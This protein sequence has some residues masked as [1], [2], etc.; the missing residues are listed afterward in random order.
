MSKNMMAKNLRQSIRHSL[1]R[2]IAIMAIIALGSAM[3]VGLK[4]TKSDMVTTG[5]EYM[6]EHNMFDLRLL[7]TYGWDI[8]SVDD[9][10]ALDGVASAEG[11]ITLDALAVRSDTQVERVYKLYAI[12]ETVNTVMLQGGRMPEAPGECLADGEYADDSALG[13]TYTISDTNDDD[14][15]DSLACR[16][17]TVVGYVSTPLYMDMSRGS[18]TIGNGTVSG[19]LY[20]PAESFDVDYYTEIDVTID[21]DYEIY[22]EEYSTAMDDAA[23][24]LEPALRQIA[25]GRYEDIRREA[26]QEYQDGLEEFS[27]ALAEYEDGKREAELSLLDGRQGLLDAQQE[28]TDGWEALEDADMQLIYAQREVDAG[29]KTLEQSREDFE[30]QKAEA[31]AELNAKQTELQENYDTVTAS[32]TQIEAALAD[33]GISADQLDGIISQLAQGIAELDSQ[34]KALEPAAQLPEYAALYQSLLEQ[35]AAYT[36][37]LAKLQETRENYALLNGYLA[38]LNNGY[39]LLEESRAAVEAELAAAEAQIADAQAQLDK[40]QQEIYTGWWEI[41]EGKN[42][43]LEAEA[44][45]A[46]GWAEYRDGREE[47]EREL[48]DAQ[49]ELTKAQVE[50]AD[51][52][53]QIDSLEQ[54]ELYILDRNTN[55]GY[56]SLDSNS[57][58]VA[59]VAKVFPAFFLLVASLVC[60]TTMTRMVEEERTQIGTL[61]ALGYSNGAI[62]GKYLA[63]A[64]SAAVLGCGLGVAVG[65]V[66]FPLVLWQ[67]YEIIFNITPHLTLLVDMGL[68]IP[69]VVSYTAVIMLVTW[70][71]CRMAL[72]DVPAELIRPKPPTSGKKIFLEYLPF[73]DK[74][75]F[76][77]KVMLRNI[78]RYR[79]RL[80]MMLV[81]IGGCTALLVT[82]FGVRDSI[83]DIVSYQFE[84]V[85]LFDIQVQFSDGMRL[86]DQEDFLEE[87]G[88]YIDEIGF[89]YQS[90]VEI[91]FD[92]NTKDITLIASTGELDTFFDFHSGDSPLVLPGKGEV[93]LSVGVAEAMDVSV[94]DTVVLRNPDMD[95]LSVTVSAIFDNNVYNY[96]IVTPETLEDQWGEVPESQMAYVM[97]SEEQ[98]VHVAG[99]KIAEQEGVMNLTISEDLAEQVGSMLEAM[100]L[101]VVTVVV[102]AGLLA[103]IVLYNLTNINITER[104]R[105]IATIKVLGFNATEAA[106]YVFKENL[107]L[108]GMGAVL[109]LFG[110]KALLNF[111]MSQIKIDMV[112]FQARVLPVSFVWAILLT[113][114]SACIV[115]LILYFKLDRI[116]M[117][118]ALKSVE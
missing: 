27:G 1:G 26:E 91:D 52:R 100:N 104:I 77:N 30:A 101:I 107:L 16:T 87:V 35:Q 102:C 59:G 4:T 24:A 53:K 19:Y 63:Y 55:I 117:A 42:D 106:A 90:S 49:L 5:A 39:A 110:G 10:A 47:A 74:I 65:S 9:I 37:Q 98:D 99:A 72:R 64:G 7:N 70:Y 25:G 17:F 33:Q 96:A 8:G 75:R 14:T 66:V 86:G 23:D 6:D 88:A 85:T 97:V 18:T 46:E 48:A 44:E 80:L 76:L 105:E 71:S 31:Y 94:G 15:L 61:K 11:V 111:V 22:S 34:I 62:I 13:T 68:C 79:Q 54:P 73:W 109:G 21:G 83:V 116:N 69:V 41:D 60:I 36:V 45:I 84:E 82:G 12:P 114:L 67:A 115:D 103:V 43:L 89:F 56:Q 118:E 58:I 38:E 28:V 108:S 50:L 92:D 29:R 113:M 3:F 95:T 78:F 32:L 112:W 81:G 40:V 93:M 57:D 51:A 2:Y 20:I